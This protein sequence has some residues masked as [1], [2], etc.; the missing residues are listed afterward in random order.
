MKEICVFAADGSLATHAHGEAVLDPGAGVLFIY[1]E[2][3][4]SRI[5]LNWDN[6][7]GYTESPLNEEG[8]HHDA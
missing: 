4:E 5:T 1:G 8:A 3:V 6:L 2:T 7:L